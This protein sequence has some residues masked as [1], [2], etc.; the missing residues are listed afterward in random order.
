MYI[1]NGWSAPT[2]ARCTIDDAPGGGA[3]IVIDL[4]RARPPTE[5]EP[6]R[7]PAGDNPVAAPDA[8]AS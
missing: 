4:A 3:R 1:V 7:R 8:G 2:A 6:C 5:P